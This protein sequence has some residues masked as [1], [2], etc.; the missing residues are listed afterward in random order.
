MG[1][2]LSDLGLAL[3]LFLITELDDGTLYIISGAATYATLHQDITFYFIVF[4]LFNT[5]L[6]NVDDALS[7][8]SHHLAAE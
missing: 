2:R 4:L 3:R 8:I 7:G 6:F 5:T 1:G